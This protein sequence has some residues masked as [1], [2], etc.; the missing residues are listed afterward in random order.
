MSRSNWFHSRGA[1]CLAGLT[2]SRLAA[3]RLRAGEAG[4]RGGR[5]A[6]TGERR[7]PRG[8]ANGC[9][10]S[11]SGQLTAARQATVRAQ[12]GGI[13]RR[14]AGRSRSGRSGGALVAKIASRDL[15]SSFESSKAGVT[16]AE[17]AL[18]VARTEHQRTEA[19]VKGGAL[20]ARDLEQTRM[21]SRSPKRSWPPR[22]RGRCPCGSR[23]TTRA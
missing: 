19:L 12:V 14:A 9:R 8:S 5:A 20:A 15:E 16:S 17:T 11:V 18:A 1:R 22:G 7:R 6:R 13:A 4:V 10:P 23:L 3:R 21:P 2:W